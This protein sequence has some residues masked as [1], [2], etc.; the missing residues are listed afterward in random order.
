MA[1]GIKLLVAVLE[2][3]M[4]GKDVYLYDFFGWF[5]YRV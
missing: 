4:A 3:Q 1:K 2:V 5:R